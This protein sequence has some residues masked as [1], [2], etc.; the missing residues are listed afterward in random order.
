MHPR[1]QISLESGRASLWRRNPPAW[2]TGSGAAEQPPI[3]IVRKAEK[4]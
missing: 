1:A 2:E 3:V 4:A